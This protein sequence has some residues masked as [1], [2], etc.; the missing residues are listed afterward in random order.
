MQPKQNEFLKE[1]S[2]AASVAKSLGIDRSTVIRIAKRCKIGTE[3]QG[4]L[5]LTLQE[6]EIIR[7]NY[8]GGP[9]NPNFKKNSRR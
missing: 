5:L 4:R 7:E 9:G 8:H 6:A 1:L 2:N 3:H